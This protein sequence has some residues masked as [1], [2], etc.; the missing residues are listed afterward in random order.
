MRTMGLFVVGLAFLVAFLLMRRNAFA[1]G[2]IKQTGPGGKGNVWWSGD[3]PIPGLPS[4]FNFGGNDIFV[5]PD[6][7]LVLEGDGFEPHSKGVFFYSAIEGAP[8]LAA[9]LLLDNR[10]NSVYGF[11]SDLFHQ[12]SMQTA[13]EIADEIVRQIAP[14][15]I[16]ADGTIP[17]AI[18]AWRDD[19]RDRIS[20]WV[21]EERDSI[22]LPE[23]VG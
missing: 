14:H 21:Q 6:C 8:N 9:S 4:E 22:G 5:S 1:S 12:R 23:L 20:L 17:P 18:A 2:E 16:D 13:P 3:G 7:D 11:I 15:C 10:S 19:F